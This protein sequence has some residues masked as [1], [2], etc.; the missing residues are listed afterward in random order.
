[1]S[2]SPMT[3]NLMAS[4]SAVLAKSASASAAVDSNFDLVRI[5]VWNTDHEDELSEIWYSSDDRDI[6]A[7]RADTGGVTNYVQGD[8]DLTAYLLYYYDP[9]T[10][11]K[12]LT[13][14][15]VLQN[16]A[17]VKTINEADKHYDISGLKW[18]VSVAFYDRARTEVSV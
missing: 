15:D 10:T 7:V 16:C 11:P 18:N 4:S 5:G 3:T 12:P 13:L 2:S 1:M 17:L 8:Y 6:Y 9:E 14:E